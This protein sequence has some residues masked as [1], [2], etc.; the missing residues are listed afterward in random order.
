MILMDEFPRTFE[1]VGPKRVAGELGEG[2]E[3]VVVSAAK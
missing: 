2:L 3:A 1:I